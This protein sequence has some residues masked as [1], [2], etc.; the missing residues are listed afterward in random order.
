[1]R[2]EYHDGVLLIF[3]II[4]LVAVVGLLILEEG[5]YGRFATRVEK[6]REELALIANRARL[7]LSTIKKYADFLHTKQFGTLTFA[8]QEAVDN[9]QGA[10]A[11]SLVQ[12]DRLLAYSRLDEARYPLTAASIHIDKAIRGVIDTVR[13]LAAAKHIS[14]QVKGKGRVSVYVDA[15]LLHGALDELLVN[16]VKYTPE[17]GRIS[18][19]ISERDR[20]VGIAV[21]DSGIGISAKE[22]PRV[23]EKFFRGARAQAMATGNGLGLAFAKSF[24]ETMNGSLSFTSTEGKGSVFLLTVPKKKSR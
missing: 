8:Q 19:E 9:L 14:V 23:F 4:V 6:T 1:M 16:A 24:A 3:N 20:G 22:K 18:V 10:L 7:P 15:L 17:H 2:V 13:P 11:E 5:R 12:V 21:R